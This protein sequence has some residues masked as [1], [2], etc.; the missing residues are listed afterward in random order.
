MFWGQFGSFNRRANGGGAVPAP[1]PAGF[2]GSGVAPE[3][4]LTPELCFQFL[5]FAVLLRRGVNEAG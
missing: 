3:F 2:G 1:P 5:F 4:L